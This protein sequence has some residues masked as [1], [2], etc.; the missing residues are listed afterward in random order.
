MALKS[1]QREHNVTVRDMR[2]APSVRAR[3]MALLCETTRNTA[4]NKECLCMLTAV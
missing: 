1:L 3:K 4:L 2:I